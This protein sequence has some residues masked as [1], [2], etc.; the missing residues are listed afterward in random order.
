MMANNNVKS[1]FRGVYKCG[2]RW[3]AQL[4]CQGIQFYL[5]TFDTEGEAAK[6]YDRKARDEKGV[7]GLTNFDENGEEA[8]SSNNNGTSFQGDL[9]DAAQP[10]S[11][12]DQAENSSSPPACKAK[13]P[14]ISTSVSCSSSSQSLTV[15]E[16]TVPSVLININSN[17]V[18]VCCYFIFPHVSNHQNR[19]II[20][21]VF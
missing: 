7:K 17:S 3:K 4:Q 16:T 8:M 14:R 12:G 9:P 5:G 1:K 19:W 2:K 21:M 20:L 10:T 15:S 13:R 11:I 18:Q 6:A